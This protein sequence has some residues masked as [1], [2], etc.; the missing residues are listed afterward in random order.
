LGEESGEVEAEFEAFGDDWTS[1][2]VTKFVNDVRNG[3]QRT[4]KSWEWKSTA[5][6]LTWHYGA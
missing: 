6:E 4:G 3:A 5:R 1:K 2:L